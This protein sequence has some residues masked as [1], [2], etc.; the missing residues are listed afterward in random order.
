MKKTVL[1]LTTTLMLMAC[2]KH[3]NPFFTEWN[4]PYGLPPFEQITDADYLPAIEEGIKQQQAEIDA[5]A[6]NGETATFENT[7]FTST[8]KL[9]FVCF[10]IFCFLHIKIIH[11]TI[12]LFI[13]R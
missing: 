12:K 10:K 6:N 1:I 9:L 5:I 7:I 11:L 2:T 3:Q 8:R 13:T 4:T